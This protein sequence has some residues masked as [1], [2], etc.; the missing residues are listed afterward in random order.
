MAYNE[1]KLLNKE[2]RKNIVGMTVRF[3]IVLRFCSKRFS[4]VASA[5]LEIKDLYLLSKV[6]PQDPFKYVIN[7]M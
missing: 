7:K 1:L 2:L 6:V 3:H 4:N 5:I